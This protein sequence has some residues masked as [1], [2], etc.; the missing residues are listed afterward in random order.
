MKKIISLRDRKAEGVLSIWWI[1]IMGIVAVGIVIG[2][3]IFYSAKLD[4]R[5]EEADILVTR[6]ADCIV[7]R[8]YIAEDFLEDSDAE[9][10]YVFRE[11]KLSEEV[12][13][14]SEDYY[15]N[16]SVYS[17]EDMEP[18]YSIDYGVRDFQM[19]YELGKLTEDEEEQFAECL[20]ES[21]FAFDKKN[22]RNVIVKIFV[23][24]AQ[25]GRKV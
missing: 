16:I 15:F 8:G 4:I 13:V 9:R 5:A 10:D 18:R 23:C 25:I 24:S 21:L 14:K 6:I 12:I 19:Q 17:R 1:S 7:Q 3:L 2:V 22:K 11:C 20:E